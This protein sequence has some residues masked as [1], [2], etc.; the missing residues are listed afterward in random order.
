MANEAIRSGGMN[1]WRIIG[2]GTAATILLLPMASMQITD[3]VKWDEADFI[4][5]GVLLGGI[6]LLL[7]L[8]VRM[9]RDPFYRGGVA[10]ALL[11]C[12]LTVWAN[13]AVGMIGDG[14]SLLNLM[15]FGVVAL[16]L[17]GAILARFR[18]EGMARAMTVAAVAQ[19]VA[20]GI[21]TFEDVRGGIYSALFGLIWLF[22]AM[23]FG[24]AARDITGTE[25]HSR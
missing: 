17:L 25:R 13:A 19:A 12:F 15:F 16:A 23:L 9:S 14:D 7:E 2:W 6:G 10:A 18:A 1:K 20:G 24:E 8:G 5:A 11:A 22:S 3:E 4:F 21:G